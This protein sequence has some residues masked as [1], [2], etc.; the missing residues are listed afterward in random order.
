MNSKN[1]KW[2]LSYSS[3][4]SFGGGLVGNIKQSDIPLISTTKTKAIEEGELTW[5]DLIKKTEKEAKAPENAFIDG[6][7]D[8]CVV[9]R[10]PL[11]GH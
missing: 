8:P 9:Y 10:I 1:G 3:R 5:E 4:N 6:P 2:Y 7:W 11:S